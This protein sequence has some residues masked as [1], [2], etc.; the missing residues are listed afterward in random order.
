MKL[1]TVKEV[2]KMFDTSEETIRRWIR[3]DKL[4]S[5]MESKKH[6]SVITEKELKKFVKN[7][8]KYATA[9]MSAIPGAF[10]APSAAT[11]AAPLG[12]GFLFA[13]LMKKNNLKTEENG[14][15]VDSDLAGEEI[16]ESL[17]VRIKNVKERI[18]SKNNIIQTIQEEIKEE[19]EELAYLE[20][21]LRKVN[22]ILDEKIIIC[23]KC[24]K[25]KP[26]SDFGARQNNKG[27]IMPQSWCKEC[28]ENFSD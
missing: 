18:K 9:L 3:D 10:V 15:K 13:N 5:T 7:K 22:K 8:P 21:L 26:G 27:E 12:I 4:Q 28:R 6:G 25:E 17:K 24:G 2:A 23:P 11:L 14:E 20:H 16:E 19:T 1:Y